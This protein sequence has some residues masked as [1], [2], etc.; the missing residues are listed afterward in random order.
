MRRVAPRAEP[1]ERDDLV[2]LSPFKGSVSTRTLHGSGCGVW[3]WITAQ[4]SARTAVG[5][6]LG[7]AQPPDGADATNGRVFTT[8]ITSLTASSLCGRWRQMMRPFGPL[9]VRRAPL[10]SQPDGLV[11]HLA[12]LTYVTPTVAEPA[13]IHMLHFVHGK[14]RDR[15]VPLASAQGIVLGRSSEV[16][17][18]LEDDT[19]SR[20]HARVSTERDCVWIRDLGSRNGTY[21]NGERTDHARLRVGDRVAIGSSLLRVELAD[22]AKL[23]S[24]AQPAN[25]DEGPRARSMTG[26]LDEIHLSVVLQ[27]LATSRKTGVLRV[28]GPAEGAIHLREGQVYTARVEGAPKLSPEKAL[29][30]VLAWEQGRFELDTST[31]DPPARDIEMALEHVLM[32]AARRQDELAHLNEKYELPTDK[33]EVVR[34]APRPWR[35]LDPVALDVLQAFLDGST[36]SQVMD[37]SSVDDLTLAKQV[38]ALARDG[39]LK[40]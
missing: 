27:W 25:V 5:T 32:E 23:E 13:Q 33:V 35:E 7:W 2:Q 8:E 28:H 30:R 16:G 26:N 4:P 3:V 19:V 39:F 18:V 20:R 6:N 14:Y 9:A 12:S 37:E 21:V 22:P 11:D 10:G 38:V 40:Y 24:L 15:E 17:L 29:F 34:P 1:C 31:G 36:W